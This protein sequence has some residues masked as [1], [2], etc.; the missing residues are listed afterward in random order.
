[1]EKSISRDCLQIFILLF[2]FLVTAPIV[3]NSHILTG[4]YF[5]FLKNVLDQ[6]KSLLIPNLDLSEKIDKVVIK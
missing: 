2:T 6:L 1:M 3:K 4:I 5:I